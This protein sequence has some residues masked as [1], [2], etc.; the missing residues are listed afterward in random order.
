MDDVEKSPKTELS[1]DEISRN[2][3]EIRGSRVLRC[4]KKIENSVNKN[5]PLESCGIPWEF[6]RIPGILENSWEF[7]YERSEDV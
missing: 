6:Y 7:N 3:V 2:P 1:S 4:T 5:I